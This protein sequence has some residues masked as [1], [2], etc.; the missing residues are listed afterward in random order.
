MKYLT[1]VLDRI[2]TQVDIMLNVACSK[3][4]VKEYAYVTRHP[5]L[6]VLVAMLPDRNA[7]RHVICSCNGMEYSVLVVDID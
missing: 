2:I 4:Y 1:I 7:V 6:L 3:W 5:V